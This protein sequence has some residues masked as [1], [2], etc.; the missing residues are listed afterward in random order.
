M[1]RRPQE[2]R[3]AFTIPKAAARRRIQAQKADLRRQKEQ[4]EPRG[5]KAEARR[6][7]QLHKAW[8]RRHDQEA[9][10]RRRQMKA[11]PKD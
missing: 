10:L 3:S 4:A 7:S 2:K 11:R 6:V 1:C 9:R 5:G 8:M